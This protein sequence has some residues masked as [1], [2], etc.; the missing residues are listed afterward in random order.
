MK[1]VALGLALLWISAATVFAGGGASWEVEAPVFDE[2]GN[3]IKDYSYLDNGLTES[4]KEKIK[5]VYEDFVARGGDTEELSELLEYK[6]KTVSAL[7]IDS[8]RI[9]VRKEA[10]SY[11][12]TLIK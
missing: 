12:A 8:R 10:Y 2:S 7:S 9:D 11:V 4:K 5:S 6:L 1:K 3:Y